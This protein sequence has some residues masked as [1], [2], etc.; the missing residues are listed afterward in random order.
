[1]RAGGVLSDVLLPYGRQRVH[2]PGL[3]YRD[4]PSSTLAPPPLL[5][6]LRSHWLYLSKP[7][8]NQ[9]SLVNKQ[10]HKGQSRIKSISP[11][12]E[13]NKKNEWGAV[14]YQPRPV[15]AM[16]RRDDTR[17]GCAA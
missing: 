4:D 6:L 7:R 1:M 15:G 14:H 8:G 11:G 12:K 9:W 16:L 10:G 17:G 13:K 2:T 3:V 5:T